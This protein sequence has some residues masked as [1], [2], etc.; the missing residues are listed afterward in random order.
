M[1]WMTVT[2]QQMSPTGRDTAPPAGSLERAAALLDSFDET[3]RE[4]T[5]AAL[6]R[7][8]G[9]PRSTVHRTAERIEPRA[10]LCARRE[11]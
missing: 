6:V 1:T 9:L 5:L 3:H 8:S 4:L 11:P 10:T 7:R 2:G